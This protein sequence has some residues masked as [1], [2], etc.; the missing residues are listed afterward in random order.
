[1]KE[2]KLTN[3]QKAT[4][5]IN[6]KNAVGAPVAVDSKP[7]WEVTSGTVTVVVS[8]DGLSAEVISGDV[9][10]AS[11]IVVSADVDLG[12]G[13]ETIQDH[14]KVFV[15]GNKATNLGLSTGQ[16]GLK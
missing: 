9:P 8:A 7:K 6:S 10:G 14:I 4:V 3:K 13:V 15:V 1:M 12:S 11:T 2:L 16:F 5:T